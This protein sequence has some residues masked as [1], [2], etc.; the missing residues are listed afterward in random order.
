M[1]VCFGYAKLYSFKK[2]KLGIKLPMAM[3]SDV[4]YMPLVVSTGFN[5]WQS[6]HKPSSVN[7]WR[8]KL[9]A[10]IAVI[11]AGFIAAL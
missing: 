5:H 3:L 2:Q 7:L 10:T 8:G 11:A 9:H 1:V 6:A 4:W